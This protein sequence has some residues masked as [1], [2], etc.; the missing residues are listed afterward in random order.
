MQKIPLM[1]AKA[2]MVLSRDVYRSEAFTG[3]P[4]CGKG[5]ELTDSL[6][7]RFEKM[8]VQTVYVDGQ[9]S[10]IETVSLEVRLQSLD[11][12]FSKT[13]NEPLNRALH[14]IYKDYLIVSMGGA[15][16]R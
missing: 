7:A 5:T 10:D 13:V 4:I 15:V 11:E 16:E 9:S 8:D 1:Q 12:R 14:Q 6:I 2:G 3:I